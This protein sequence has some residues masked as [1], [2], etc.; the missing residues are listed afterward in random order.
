[1]PNTLTVVKRQIRAQK[2]LNRAEPVFPCGLA[3]IPGPGFDSQ[4]GR[5]QPFRVAVGQSPRDWAGTFVV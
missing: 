2:V 3:V 1:M 5:E 4:H